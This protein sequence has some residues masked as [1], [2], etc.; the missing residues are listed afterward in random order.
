MNDA[1][2]FSIPFVLLIVNT[3]LSIVG[4]LF[5][6]SLRRSM[7]GG[8]LAKTWLWLSVA[9]F[10]L[11]MMEAYNLLLGLSVV[12]LMVVHDWIELFTVTAFVI[13][14]VQGRRALK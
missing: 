4:F 2:S 8:A 1:S 7:A 3:I 6:V 9:S 12:S 13:A 11:M 10:G 5:A 14:F